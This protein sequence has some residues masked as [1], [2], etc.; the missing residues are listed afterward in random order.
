MRPVG[1][2]ASSPSPTGVV[3]LTQSASSPSAAA[4]STSRSASSFVRLYGTRS[5]HSGGPSSSVAA[6]PSTGPHVPAVL[7]WTSR[8]TPAARHAASTFRVPPTFTASSSEA[9]A[10]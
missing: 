10:V 4:A 8:P 9:G 3:G 1:V 7:V 2:G 6:R 5:S